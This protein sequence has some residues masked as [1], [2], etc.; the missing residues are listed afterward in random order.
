MS[1]EY[2]LALLALHVLARRPA[3]RVLAALDAARTV[4]ARHAGQIIDDA[5]QIVA[6]YEEA[7]GAFDLANPIIVTHRR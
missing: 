7:V 3:A 5:G 4:T 1:P 6:V 2:E